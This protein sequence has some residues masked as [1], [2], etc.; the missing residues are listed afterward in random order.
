M[1]YSSKPSTARGR[2]AAQTISRVSVVGGWRL[3]SRQPSDLRIANRKPANRHGQ[4]P[5][6]TGV[7]YRSRSTKNSAPESAVPRGAGALFG[8]R[9]GAARPLE[10]AAR[11]RARIHD[12]P[13]YTQAS[14]KP[15]PVGSGVKPPSSICLRGT[16]S[17][18][19]GRAPTGDAVSRRGLTAAKYLDGGMTPSRV[20]GDESP[21][22]RVGSIWGAAFGV[23]RHL[24]SDLNAMNLTRISRDSKLLP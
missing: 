7:R 12:A 6:F 23:G 20:V 22:S 14:P 10:V 13:P 3:S 16:R 4:C 19:L 15:H 8:A 11:Q 17:A 5:R 9:V 2:D 1:G 21:A 24:G 18:R